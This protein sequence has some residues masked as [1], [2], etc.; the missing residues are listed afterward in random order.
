MED[1]AFGP[2]R[3]PVA[4]R[5]IVLENRRA[6]RQ[7][8]G[9]RLIQCPHG[10][11]DPQGLQIEGVAASLSDAVVVD[12]R[13]G[14]RRGSEAEALPGGHNITGETASSLDAARVVVEIG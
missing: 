5:A 8:T 11:E 3:S 10:C 4:G 9:L 13:E 12:G 6:S 14:G 2:L 7:I 1:L